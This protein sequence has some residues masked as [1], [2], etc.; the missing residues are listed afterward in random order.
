MQQSTNYQLSCG[1]HHLPRGI[2]S[3]GV[4]SENVSLPKFA[5]FR[6]TPELRL[7]CSM[8]HYFHQMICLYQDM[9]GSFYVKMLWEKK[10]KQILRM[11]CHKDPEFSTITSKK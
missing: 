11:F 9:V 6:P 7:L 3:S 1:G 4:H 10:I 8:A 5:S 2:Q